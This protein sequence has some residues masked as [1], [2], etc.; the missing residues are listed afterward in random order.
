MKTGAEHPLEDTS[1]L[2]RRLGDLARAR[3]PPGLAEF[4][5][6]VLKQDRKS[7]V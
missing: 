5:M 2:E 1:G 3:L 6:F 7:V 4:V